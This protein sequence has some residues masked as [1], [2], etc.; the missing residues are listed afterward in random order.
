MELLLTRITRNEFCTIAELL[1][2]SVHECFICEDVD[3]GL[4]QSMPLEEIK[5]VKVPGKTAIPSGRYEVV[6]SFSNRFQKPLPLL[7]GVP[8][9]EGIRIHPGNTAADTEGCLLPGKVHTDVSVG[10]SREAFHDLFD[11]IK[12]ATEKV[13]ITIQ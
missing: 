9:F 10:N 2:D 8:G 3:R 13:F 1:V 12:A 11:K 7:L 4:A 6:V 5:S